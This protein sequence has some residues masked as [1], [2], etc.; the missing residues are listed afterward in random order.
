MKLKKIDPRR[1]AARPYCPM[2]PPMFTVLVTVYKCLALADLEGDPRDARPLTS[3]ENSWIRLYAL[4]FSHSISG[5]AINIK[6]HL[7]YVLFTT[8]CFVK[9]S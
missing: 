5:F 9:L 8:L 3:H 1:A 2:D 4:G 6:Q 7:N